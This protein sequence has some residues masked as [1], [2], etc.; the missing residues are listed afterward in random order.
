M[1]R[2]W[3]DPVDGLNALFESVTRSSWRWECQGRYDVDRAGLERWLRGEPEIEDDEDRAWVAYI[4]GL[5]RAGI[6]FERVRMLADPP[7]D[8]NRWMLDITG[9]NVAAGESIRWISEGRAR[10]LGMPTYDFYLFDEARLAVLR[11]DR[12]TVLTGVEVID[13]ENVVDQ[14]RQLR[15]QVWPLAVPHAEYVR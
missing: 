14:H 5:T 13:D 1:T 7:T 8:Y 4:Q 10:E 6:P 12:D 2:R 15:D 11:F 9:R 3:A